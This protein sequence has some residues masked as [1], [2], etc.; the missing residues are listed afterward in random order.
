MSEKKINSKKIALSSLMIA[1]SVILYLTTNI[2]ILMI[3]GILLSPVPLTW[4]GYNYGIKQLIIAT[5]AT[6]FIIFMI[7]GPFQAYLFFTMFGI[8]AIVTGAFLYKNIKASRTIILGTLIIIFFNIFFYYGIE[9]TLGLED[10]LKEFSDM[11][12][13]YSALFVNKV[14]FMLPEAKR[15]LMINY[16]GE[17]IQ[18]LIRFPLL[19][20]S[21]ISFAMIYINYFVCS[22]IFAR[23]GKPV[24]FIEP[25][26]FWKA[27]WWFIIFF[28]STILLRS[29]IYLN[30]SQMTDDIYFNIIAIFYISYF[31]LGLG[32]FNF[33][34]IRYSIP[35]YIRIP[36]L[37]ILY[38]YYFIPV[39]F[40]IFDSFIDFRNIKKI[41]EDFSK[42]LKKAQ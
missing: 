22:L 17:M 34:F 25:I 41:R 24:P 4:I 23:L 30:P 1:F 18:K 3:A 26:F 32:M 20:F 40:G 28:M 36:L 15:I 7:I 16:L 12:K 5:L 13:P 42:K 29:N 11:S 9:K 33:F 31:F 38:F 37:I 35:W 14:Y 21:F 6:T 10:M 27:P 39:I 2:P 8:V 19:L